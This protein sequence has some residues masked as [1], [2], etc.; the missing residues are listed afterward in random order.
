MVASDRL[1][2]IPE[3]LQR[4]A[5]PQRPALVRGG[6]PEES[7][8]PAR[9]VT[10]VAQAEWKPIHIPTPNQIGIPAPESAVLPV[11]TMTAPARYDLATVTA[12]LDQQGVRSCQRER[13][14]EG[15]RF[16][17]SLAPKGLAE[18]TLSARG[19]TDEEA[20]KLLVQEVMRYRQMSSVSMR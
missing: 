3:M 15:V 13:L 6:A 2:P 20:L 7:T 8:P 1:P 5:A 12:W 19:T 16:V 14:T 9:P 11:A 10:R 4:P 18:Q 17:C